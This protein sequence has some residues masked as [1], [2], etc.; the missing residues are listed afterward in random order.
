MRISSLDIY[1][2][3]V[4]YTRPEVSHL[5][6]RSGVTDVIIKLTAD[7]GLVGWGE[8]CMNCDAAGIEATL[9]AARPIVLGRDP[10]DKEAIARDF[11]IGGGWQF[12]SMTGN[13]AFAGLDMAFW[14]L[15]GKECGQPLYRLL[16]G[17]LREDVDYFYYLQWGDRD[18]IEAQCRDG[19]A[20]GYTVFYFKVGVDERAEEAMIETIRSTIGPQCK[21]RIDANQ[22][23]SVPE[24]VRIINSWHA[25]YRIDVVEAPVRA[26]P[27]D[28]TRSLKAQVNTSLCANEG[29]WHETDVVDVIFSRAVDYLCFST[30]WVGSIRRFQSLIHLAD[31][32]GQLVCKHTHGELGLAAAA[33]QHAMLAAPNASDGHQ[34]TAQMMADDILT[35][36]LP[37]ADGPKWGR[38]EGPGLGVE[39]DV[40]KVMRYHED[41]RRLG[42]FQPFGERFTP[43][44]S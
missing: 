4:A 29:L 5:I 31:L 26:K 14:D 37:I 21:L 33:G 32:E 11:F 24:A 9:H 19:V 6:S 12:Q 10:W 13:F 41:Y 23:W 20:R 18:D 34:Q 42:N 15:C 1:P 38:I 28:I 35:E 7:S 36:R 3:R 44:P 16:G 22:A 30:Y 2:V 40:D 17:A 8:A 43:S 39:V 25:K 27:I